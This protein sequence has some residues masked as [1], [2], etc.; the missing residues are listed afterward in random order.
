MKKL[1]YFGWV[2]FLFACSSPT[3]KTLVF[4]PQ[5]ATGKVAEKGEVESYSLENF[6]EIDTIQS[7]RSI[8]E[9]KLSNY[10]SLVLISTPKEALHF[11][12]QTEIERFIQAGGKVLELGKWDADSIRNFASN[13]AIINYKNV[14]IPRAPDDN[15]FSK[16][17]LHQRFDEPMELAVMST[18]NV[19]IVERKGAVKMY[20]AISR[21][22]KK[23]GQ[24]PANDF[25]E[26]GLLGIA[27]D[28]AFDQN[29]WI[30]LFYSPIGEDPVQFVSR[31]EFKDSVILASE[32]VLLKIPTQRLECCHSAGSLEFGPKGN[33][34]ISVGDNTNPF[35]SNGYDPIDERP[36][37]FP[38]DA[39]RSSGNTHDLRGKILRI[40]PE[41]DGTYSI[42][43][44]NLFPKDGSKGRPEIY[45][46]GCRNPFRFAIDPR[47][48]YLYWGEIGP[49][50]NKDD[51]N[52]GP[53]GHDEFNQAKEPGFYGWPYFVGNNKAYR[54]VKYLRGTGEGVNDIEKLIT[55]E[56]FDPEHP[57]NDSPNNTGERELPPA[58]PAFIYYPYNRS[59][60]FPMLGAGSRNAMAGQI[61]YSDEYLSPTAFPPF[62]DG[63]PF[64]YDWM[65]NWVFL[66]KM[67][68][69]GDLIRLERFAPQIKYNNLMDMEF[70]K[71]G[72]L[73]TLEYG[74]GW[75]L[76]NPDSRLSRVSYNPGNRPPRVSISAN[77]IT[78]SVP[79]TVQ[80]TSEVKED[81]GDQVKYKWWFDSEAPQSNEANPSFTF[82]KPGRFMVLLKVEDEHGAISNAMLEIQAGNEAPQINFQ[83][84]E[85]Q[86]ISSNKSF[87]WQGMPIRYALSVSDKEDGELG[88]GID[89]EAVTLTI[90]YL[91]EGVDLTEVIQGH[92]SG[93][94][95]QT[96]ERLIKVNNCQS[97]HQEKE[98]LVGPGFLQVAEKYR[99]QADAVDYLTNKILNGGSGVWGGQAMA[100]QAQLSD[101]E[102]ERIAK[103]ILELGQEKASDSQPLEGT[104]Q[105]AAFQGGT[106][107]LEASYTD[108]GGPKTDPITKYEQLILMPDGY[109]EAENYDETLGIIPK[110]FARDATPYL[111]N[112]RPGNHVLYHAIDL[113]SVR[114]VQYQWRDVWNGTIEM[115]LD[116]LDG[117]LLCSHTYV[118][119][120]TKADLRQAISP[121]KGFHDIYLVFKHDRGDAGQV[122]TLDGIR[123]NCR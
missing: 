40:K 92:Q 9:E 53:R 31:F 54:D 123:F 99:N 71:D 70:G 73:Y 24:I 110:Q 66:V 116:S 86:N 4:V 47:T 12:Q 112:L 57:I 102:A 1:V 122:G 21:K 23:V 22:V 44:G 69:N 118:Q 91:A 68:E 7:A 8:Q 61:Y 106:F 107:V 49:D 77:K 33:L 97:C 56:F 108:D 36:G 119:D 81:D 120:V 13:Q 113:S 114:S 34:W 43:D 14:T 63:K 76:E 93:A 19:L 95:A 83:F 55:D 42:P 58:Q 26:D 90:D 50:A 121:Q 80:F 67:D 62:F 15:R 25:E 104:I 85:N 87:W 28:P 41:P 75:F 5:K 27:L 59:A 11:H 64:F 18:G 65:R 96:G 52:R 72:S 111:D 46:M 115:R 74:T 94:T 38:F 117:P 105:T 84:A 82:E 17:V 45:I 37:R 29:H 100:A 79:M 48:Y 30:Y 98:K 89:P 51:E 3:S 6:N 39:Q 32:K 20:D 2:F 88:A 35:E 10:A 60:E 103:Y 101:S 78:G 109:I 16:Q